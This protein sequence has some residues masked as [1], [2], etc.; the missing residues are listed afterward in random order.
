[1][2]INPY[3][4]STLVFLGIVITACV[5]LAGVEATLACLGTGVAFAAVVGMC[6]FVIAGISDYRK[7]VHLKARNRR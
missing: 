5:C 2:K 4:I 7:I 6:G 3:L 1:M